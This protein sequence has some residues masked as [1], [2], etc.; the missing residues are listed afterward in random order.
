MPFFFMPLSFFTKEYISSVLTLPLFLMCLILILRFLKGE[1][2]LYIHPYVIILISIL[3]FI[4]AIINYQAAHKFI[5]YNSWKHFF[6]FVKIIIL[7]F[8]NYSFIKQAITTRK[9]IIQFLQGTF[10]FL[11]IAFFIGFI[12]EIYLKTKYLEG[13]VSFI[14]RFLEAQWPKTYSFYQKGSYV[15]T[16][17]RINGLSQ[18]ASIFASQIGVLSFPLLLSLLKNKFNLFFKLKRR[19]TI[20]Y[21]GFF[22]L[23]TILSILIKST[24]GLILVV[25]SWSFL[26]LIIFNNKNKKI[27]LI[28]FSSFMLALIVLIFIYFGHPRVQNFLNEY[29]VQKWQN[30]SGINR[31]AISLGLFKIFLQHPIFGVGFSGPYLFSAIAKNV[32]N[33]PEFITFF[34]ADKYLPQL[35]ELGQYLANYGLIA[36]TPILY[37]FG[38]IKINFLQ[39]KK[40][41]FTQDKLIPVINDMMTYFLIFFIISQISVI[42]TINSCYLFT[43]FLFPAALEILKKNDNRL[44]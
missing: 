36:I 16:I 39:L 25:L 30:D 12:Q 22:L 21:I 20:L 35:S 41:N 24:S 44:I 19:N 5:D 38:K 4:Q 15:Q 31:T 14:G 3:I 37:Y 33:N 7:I 27:Q 23:T 2:N 34:L 13:L 11:G 10:A 6:Q 1:R 8:I 43:L 29:L 42:R 40:Y 26:F 32:H 9:H 17:P 18:E 28:I